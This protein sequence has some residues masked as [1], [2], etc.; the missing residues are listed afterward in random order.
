MLPD[1]LLPAPSLLSGIRVL[2][3]NNLSVLSTKCPG[4]RTL[5]QE[6]I[7]FP[8]Y[9]TG[10]TDSVS[11]SVNEG[12]PTNMR[13]ERDYFLILDVAIGAENMTTVVFK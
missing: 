12:P 10:L 7:A 8:L 4:H 1:T 9:Y 6:T 5:I 2:G 3:K 11:V 13:L